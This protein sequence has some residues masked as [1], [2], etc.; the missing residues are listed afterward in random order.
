MSNRVPLNC[1]ACG[2]KIRV[3]KKKRETGLLRGVG[4]ITRSRSVWSFRRRRGGRCR[5]SPTACS[6]CLEYPPQRP[7][8][9]QQACPPPSRSKA[10][11]PPPLASTCAVCI[12][13]HHGRARPTARGPPLPLPLPLQRAAAA[14]R[15]AL[16]RQA[17]CQWQGGARCSAFDP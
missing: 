14:L 12:L 7:G 2:R 8:N 10:R 9:P 3:G 11:A 17:L 15:Q 1:P 4:P 6:A 13:P 5:A 16:P